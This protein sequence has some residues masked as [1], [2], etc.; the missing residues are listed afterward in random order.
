MQVEVHAVPVARP[1]VVKANPRPRRKLALAHIAA[2][3]QVLC[4]VKR[5]TSF[6]VGT[7]HWSDTTVDQGIVRTKVSKMH[8]C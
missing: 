2:L 4:S 1:V 7:G 8:E 5:A 3:V 6:G